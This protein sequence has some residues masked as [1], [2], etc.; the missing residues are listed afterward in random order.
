M[1][2]NT[3]LLV[4]LVLLLGLLAT[5]GCKYN[6]NQILEK[7]QQEEASLIKVEIH[8]NTNDNIKAYVKSLGV[9]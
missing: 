1:Q 2:K 6:F 3:K 8:F 9:E 5:A 7:T 4:V